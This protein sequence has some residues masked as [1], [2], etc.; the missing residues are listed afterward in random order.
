MLK[1]N[2]VLN[3]LLG[4]D[5]LKIIQRP[6]MFNFSLDS[7][8]LANF[9]TITK[10]AT[11]IIDL[12]TGNA[13]IPM[14]LS[15]RT[16]ASIIGVE[17]QDESFEL[18]CRNI[19]INH[20]ENQIQIV[21]QDLKDVNKV[22]GHQLFDVVTCNP[23][24]FKVNEISHL[25][26]NDYLTIARH[27]VLATLD[28]VVKEANQLLKHG[29]NFAMVH[30][31]DRLIEIIETLR[32]YKLEPKRLRFVYP[33]PGKEANTILIEARKSNPGGLKI[34]PPLYVYHQDGTYTDE[35]LEMF[36]LKK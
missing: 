34:L 12:G 33:K 24:F 9:V 36:M 5:G 31:P 11:R 18:A 26:K 17:I 10:R 21:H 15:L 3:D 16:N 27:E 13:P 1:D 35:I 32:K 19:A 4:Y 8:L 23:P 7:T 2:E 14:F 25:N 6:D 28:D 22:V 29:G 30:R 20:L